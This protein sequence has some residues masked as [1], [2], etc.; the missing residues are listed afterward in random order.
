VR[1]VGLDQ[2]ITKF[3]DKN[4]RGLRDCFE[5]FSTQSISQFPKMKVDNAK[6]FVKKF[7]EQLK[8]KNASQKLLRYIADHLMVFG[9]K[10]LGS[11]LLINKF[12]PSDHSFFRV[13]QKAFEDEKLLPDIE[14]DN[15]KQTK[16]EKERAL[17]QKKI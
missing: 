16:L 6:A 3:I 8:E 11:N 2:E 12:N 14:Y 1:A 15:S 4:L 9:P 10:R 13:I 17:N 7:F 5:I